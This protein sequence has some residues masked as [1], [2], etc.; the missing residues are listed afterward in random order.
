MENISIILVHY[1]MNPDRSELS[2]RSLESLIESSKHLSVELIVIDNGGSTEDSQKFLEK[3]ENNEIQHYIRNSSNLW[4]GYARNQGLNISTGE[5]IA[6]V[7]ND[8]EYEKGWVEDCVKMLKAT[9]GKK[10]MA[11][12]LEVDRAHRRDKYYREPIIIDGVEH[13]NNI[14]AGSNC[15]MMRRKDY[16]NIGGFMNHTLAGTKWCRQYIKLGYSIVCA[17][18]PLVNHLGTKGTPYKGY[19]KHP[20]DKKLII[21]KYLNGEEEILNTKTQ[22]FTKD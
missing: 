15:W 20:K 4:F 8:M 17:K 9:E 6:I 22:G 7:D 3:V 13:L 1:A 19:S 14:F 11:T 16:E 5:Y 10:I 2:H 21:K 12:P 18:S